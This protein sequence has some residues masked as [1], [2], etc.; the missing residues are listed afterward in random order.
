MLSRCPTFV[1]SI[2]ELKAADTPA[3]REGGALK[4][5]GSRQ[6]PTSSLNHPPN[7]SRLTIH[8]SKSCRFALYVYRGFRVGSN[9]VIIAFGVWA[10]FTIIPPHPGSLMQCIILS[11][12]KIFDLDRGTTRNPSQDRIIWTDASTVA[13][14]R[15]ATQLTRRTSTAAAAAMSL[16]LKIGMFG[17]GTVGGGE[18]RT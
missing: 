14:H 15:T 5:A 10:L 7:D 2:A 8:D 12:I 17:G 9:G 13:L 1:T 16:P 6:T 18:A 11:C 4:A 3:S